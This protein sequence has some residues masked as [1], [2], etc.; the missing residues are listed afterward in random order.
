M[1]A[2]RAS[3]LL[4]LEQALAERIV[5]KD[6]AVAKVCQVVRVHL[7]Q[8]DFHP[9]RPKGSFLLVGPTGVGKNELAFALSEALFGSEDRVISIDLGDYSEEGDV[10]R[11]AATLVPGSKT[12]A[13]DGALTS[14]VRKQP[15]SVIL[16]RG[17]ER[18]HPS[19]Q[20]PLLQILDRGRIDDVLGPVS[21]SQAIIF[22]TTRPRRDESSAVEIGFSRVAL[23]AKEALRKRLERAFSPDL[24]EAFDE[25]IELPPPT[26]EDV[27]RIARYKV[28]AVLKR[29]HRRNRQ[30]AVADSVF[31]AFIP[32]EEAHLDAPSALNRTLETRLFNPLARFI[33]S[34][35]GTR[36]IRVDM[37]NGNLNIHE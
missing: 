19:L 18:S 29:L 37:D 30:I 1:T 17:L 27:R 2:H 26:P 16:L 24:L 13:V 31:E 5:G 21:F 3:I 6:D 22:V 11:L 15:E 8:L 34:H 14:A 7:A 25:I 9:D 35:R 10:V 32:A 28:E 23:P 20:A 33:L 12:Q 36:S 4:C